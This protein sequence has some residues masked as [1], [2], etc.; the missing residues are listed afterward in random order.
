MREI[1]FRAWDGEIKQL[2]SVHCIDW[3]TGHV[4][5]SNVAQD[6]TSLDA[7][8]LMQFTGL[9]DKNGKE[10]FESDLGRLYCHE[11]CRGIFG[12][13]KW[14]NDGWWIITNKNH[15]GIG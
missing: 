15:D 7:V 11:E 9:K 2:K 12:E 14:W 3:D 1:K 8:M 5:F 6:W 10:I 4:R 13:I